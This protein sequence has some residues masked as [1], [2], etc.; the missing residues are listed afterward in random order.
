MHIT[1]G[2]IIEVKDTETNGNLFYCNV[3]LNGTDYNMVVEEALKRL[4]KKLDTL[5]KPA[6]DLKSFLDHQAG[7]VVDDGC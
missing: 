4:K 3:L 2:V 7:E 6:V 1:E 5:R